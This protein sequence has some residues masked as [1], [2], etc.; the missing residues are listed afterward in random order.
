M[1]ILLVIIHDNS[2]ASD[3]GDDSDNTSKIEESTSNHVLALVNS[4]VGSDFQFTADDF[5]DL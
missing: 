5:A 2:S 3:Y 4:G 1:I